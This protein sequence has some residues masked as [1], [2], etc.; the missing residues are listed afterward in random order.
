MSEMSFRRTSTGSW[1][2]AA[3][4]VVMRPWLWRSALRFVPR[5]PWRPSQWRLAR[6]YVRFRMTTAYGR[7]D[8][9][10]TAAEVVEF[11]SW[12]RSFNRQ[13]FQR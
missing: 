7:P 8:A 11:L 3:L 2:L 6:K 12:C 5:R 1:R 10:P 9:S 4:A 13:R